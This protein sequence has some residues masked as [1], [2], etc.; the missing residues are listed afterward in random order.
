MPENGEGRSGCNVRT[1]AKLGASAQTTGMSYGLLM[2][3]HPE[4]G[5]RHTCWH[6]QVRALQPN[7][8]YYGRRNARH[9]HYVW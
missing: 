1:T 3:S 5:N 6:M 9:Q 8:L 4:L 7:I 2:L